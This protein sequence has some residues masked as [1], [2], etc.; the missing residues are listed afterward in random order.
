M[1]FDLQSVRTTVTACASDV[2][3]YGYFSN[4]LASLKQA[5]EK[6]KTNLYTFYE[7]LSK[8]EDTN[9]ERRFTCSIASFALFYP[10]DT[11]NMERY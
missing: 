5:V 8:I 6:T 7:R 4:N 11:V 2:G 10:M 3:T 1:T 9:W